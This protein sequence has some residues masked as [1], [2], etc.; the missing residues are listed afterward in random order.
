MSN[1][2][3]VQLGYI[4]HIIKMLTVILNIQL[5][6]PVIFRA[7]MSYIMEYEAQLASNTSQSENSNSNTQNA[8]MSTEFYQFVKEYPLFKPT[9]SSSNKNKSASGYSSLQEDISLYAIQLLNRDLLQLRI[10]LNNSRK[11]LQAQQ[12]NPQPSNNPAVAK[13]NFRS[14][15]VNDLLTNLRLV[16]ESF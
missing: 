10:F 2:L 9:S 1:Q 6:Y 5:R 8:T 4:C 15:S 11:S 7:S 16:F 13:V 3:A 14:L 12:Q